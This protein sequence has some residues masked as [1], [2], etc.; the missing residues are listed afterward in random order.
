MNYS[1]GLFSTKN[2]A[3]ANLAITRMVKSKIILDSRTLN[4]HPLELFT[5]LRTV[6][7]QSH[8]TRYLSAKPSDVDEKPAGLISS[9]LQFSLSF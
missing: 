4:H 9:V 6:T 7:N 3:R 1:T 2:L 5:L 8:L